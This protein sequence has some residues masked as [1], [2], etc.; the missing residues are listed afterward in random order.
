MTKLMKIKKFQREKIIDD[1]VHLSFE[2]RHA[3]ELKEHMK[4][5][6]QAAEFSQVFTPA[7]Y[8]ITYIHIREWVD[9]CMQEI[10]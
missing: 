9:N 8:F 6:G 4:L 5:V 2:V 1:F 7:S 3:E 10:Y